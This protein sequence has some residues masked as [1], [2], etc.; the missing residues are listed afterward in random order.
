MRGIK[1]A[2]YCCREPISVVAALVNTQ[3]GQLQILDSMIVTRL[4]E[5]VIIESENQFQE[6]FDFQ[7]I[8]LPLRVRNRRLGDRFQPL[9]MCG[10]KK[11]KDFFI[12]AKVPP[13]LRERVPILVSGDEI[14]W[15]VGY[16]MSDRFKVT[17]STRQKLA[18][19]FI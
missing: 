12:D 3:S 2:K 4:D 13:R 14:L 9:G 11:L 15:V 6:V 7:K 5:N 8:K 17:D 18:V 16:R 19:S 1:A 10:E